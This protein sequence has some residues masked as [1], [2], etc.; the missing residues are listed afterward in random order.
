MDFKAAGRGLTNLS[1]II[2]NA[3]KGRGG[4]R[5]VAQAGGGGMG[6]GRIPPNLP[7]PAGGPHLPAPRG[8]GG[9]LGPA[10]IIHPAPRKPRGKG[11][12]DA[13]DVTTVPNAKPKRTR[14]AGGGSKAKGASWLEKG[15][16]GLGVGGLGLAVLGRILG[17]NQEAA[18]KNGVATESPDGAK[19]EGT[20]PDGNV[21]MDR[22]GEMI[23]PDQETPQE[24]IARITQMAHT[25]GANRL[26]SREYGDYVNSQLRDSKSPMNDAIRRAQTQMDYDKRMPY[27]ATND[28]VR[29]WGGSDAATNNAYKLYQRGIITKDQLPSHLTRG[30]I[31]QQGMQGMG[32]MG[33][34]GMPENMSPAYQQGQNEIISPRQADENFSNGMALAAQEQ[35]RLQAQSNQQ[36]Q[37][38]SPSRAAMLGAGQPQA[39]MS[40]TISDLR[41]N[42]NSPQSAV[43]NP[44]QRKGFYPDGTPIPE[45]E[46]EQGFSWKDAGINAA[47][48]ID[49]VSRGIGAGRAIAAGAKGGAGVNSATRLALR[50]G[51]KITKGAS[52]FS[53][54]TG[55]T[56]GLGKLNVGLGLAAAG[57]EGYDEIASGH[58]AQLYGSGA[59]ARAQGFGESILN[60]LSAG[61]Y[62]VVRGNLDSDFARH[63]QV[64]LDPLGTGAGIEGIYNFIADDAQAQQSRNA[65]AAAAKRQAGYTQA[66]RDQIGKW[67]Q[68]GEYVPTSQRA[69]RF[70]QL[71][72]LND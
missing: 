53:K 48:S 6:G 46:A 5:G 38:T 8:S 39:E 19:K 36:Y 65:Y 41:D 70:K 16:A 69:Q 27:V 14:G 37:N 30:N 7:V 23:R 24:R 54:V 20:Q 3:V 47:L 25:M 63:N 62:D 21:V 61:G 71:G 1:D 22:N 40:Q 29:A 52:T 57:L 72:L 9:A 15:M 66:Q 33:I 18:N 45:N 28:E 31:E 64:N 10:D 12:D 59:R 60:S 17:N 35:A 56:S 51:D 11:F 50:G 2:G 49:D 42:A 55:A 44:A 67:E 58:R 26:N 4:V 34:Y 32:G 13:I 68:E 43:T